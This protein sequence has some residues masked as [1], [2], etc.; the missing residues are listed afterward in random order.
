LLDVQ[1]RLVSAVACKRVTK[2]KVVYGWPSS[3]GRARHRVPIFWIWKHWLLGKVRTT[4]FRRVPNSC[5][6]I[7]FFNKLSP[8]ASALVAP[9]N[10][11]HAVSAVLK[12]ARFVAQVKRA[13][14]PEHV[15]A[16]RLSRIRATQ[17]ARAAKTDAR[18][19]RL[20]RGGANRHASADD[21]SHASAAD[22][23]GADL[24]TVAAYAL[25]PAIR[26]NRNILRYDIIPPVKATLLGAVVAIKVRKI[27]IV[28]D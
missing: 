21:G 27:G 13:K 1:F 17:A 24:S 10:P 11:P 14:R 16:I 18:A 9:A 5:V 20:L 12:P 6:G 23:S 7:Y 28:I 26:G 3:N 22:Y 15:S 2:V 25:I 4:L 8:F 19:D